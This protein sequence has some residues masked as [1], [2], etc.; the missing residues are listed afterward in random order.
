MNNFVRKA[1]KSGRCNAFSQH[2]ESEFS[3]EMFII[4]SKKLNGNGEICEILE[5]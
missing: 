3:D 1:I 2:Y 5:K 4:I